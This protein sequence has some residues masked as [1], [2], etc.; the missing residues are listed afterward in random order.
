MHCR[1]D[2]I[3]RQRYIVTGGATLVALAVAT[4]AHGGCASPPDEPIALGAQIGSDTG[5][6]SGSGDI[7]PSGGGGGGGGDGGDVHVPSD[8]VGAGITLAYAGH[9]HYTLPAWNTLPEV[10]VVDQLLI[11]SFVQPDFNGPVTAQGVSIFLHVVGD[12]FVDTYVFS[13]GPGEP[14]TS[15][16]FQDPNGY[17]FS[18]SGGAPSQA[19][20][21]YTGR[22]EIIMGQAASTQWTALTEWAIP[23]LYIPD[24]WPPVDSFR[25]FGPSPLTI[26]LAAT[27]GLAT[28]VY[29]AAAISAFGGSPL[30]ATATATCGRSILT[31]VGVY[32]AAYI[33]TQAVVNGQLALQ[34][35]A[36]GGAV[37]GVMAAWKQQVR[38]VLASVITSV[39][40]CHTSVGVCSAE[41]VY[42][43]GLSQNPANA[44]MCAQNQR[45]TTF[46]GAAVGFAVTLF[47]V[48]GTAVSVPL[49][50][51]FGWA[52]G[53]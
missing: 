41:A 27:A 10:Q 39:G 19:G 51:N 34:A 31:S 23:Q 12:P 33:A 30:C 35:A 22:P 6:G 18:R 17:W 36:A 38:T 7:P 42:Y 49:F 8:I 32:T 40:V 52:N 50:Q 46:N 13:F 14:G 45:L 2:R 26:S 37:V 28:L 4:L 48:G 25:S 20:P 15:N 16:A 24:G 29:G 47:L 53:N 1:N 21:P 43:C 44:A 9:A 11:A 3:E 5:S